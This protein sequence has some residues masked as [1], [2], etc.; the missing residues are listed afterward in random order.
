MWWRLKVSRRKER[1]LLDV[2][3]HIFYVSNFIMLDI[4][5][6]DCKKQGRLNNALSDR[7]TISGWS[8]VILRVRFIEVLN[9]GSQ[10]L[11]LLT[12]VP[13]QNIFWEIRMQ[14]LFL[15]RTISWLRRSIVQAIFLSS[16]SAMRHTMGLRVREKH[17]GGRNLTPSWIFID[18]EGES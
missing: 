1:N 9:Y 12:L 4:T 15:R 2:G 7:Q 5:L 11:Y 3:Q 10:Q 8:A 17:T 13:I 16:L 18:E 6:L 14:P